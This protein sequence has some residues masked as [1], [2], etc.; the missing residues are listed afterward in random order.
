MESVAKEAILVLVWSIGKRSGW[1]WCLCR[2]E[3]VGWSRE[4]ACNGG[5]RK[6]R[7]EMAGTWLRWRR[8]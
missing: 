1:W 6:Q 7:S 4:D 8:R 2:V 3:M 5:V